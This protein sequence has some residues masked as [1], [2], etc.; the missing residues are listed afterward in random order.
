MSTTLTTRPPLLRVLWLEDEPAHVEMGVSILQ[1][2]GFN[3]Q[4][5]V[6][7]TRNA[8]EQCVQAGGFDVVIADFELPSWNGL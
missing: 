5:E 3:V 7:A 8:F 4:V 1:R 6:V 2:G